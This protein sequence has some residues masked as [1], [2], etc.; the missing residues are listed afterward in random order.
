MLRTIRELSAY[1]RG[2]LPFTIPAGAPVEPAQLGPNETKP[3][4]WVKP[5][6]FKPYTIERHDAE[7]YGVCVAA[8]DVSD[9]P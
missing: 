4:Y 1:T 2:G 6:A 8:E 9:T 5:E 7:Y 3:R